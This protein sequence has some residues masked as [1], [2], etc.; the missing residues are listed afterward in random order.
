[1]FGF[2]RRLVRRCECEMLWP[3]P[4]PLPQTS[5]LAATVSSPDQLVERTLL[6]TTTLSVTCYFCAQVLDAQYRQLRN[7]TGCLAP[8]PN[9]DSLHNVSDPL[10]AFDA[11]AVLAWAR[12]ATAGLRAER[13]RI[14]ALN[15]FPVADSD[16]GTNLLLTFVD[17]AT[18]L[19]SHLEEKENSDVDAGEALVVLA[20]GALRGARGSSGTI[21]SQ[22]LFGVATELADQRVIHRQDFARALRHA[23]DSAWEAVSAPK[24]GTILSVVRAAADAATELEGAASAVVARTVAAART[25]LVETQNQLDVLRRAGVVDAGGT[26]LLVIFEALLATVAGREELPARSAVAAI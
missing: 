25:A 7:S 19:E 21:L 14:D 20:R 3:K 23:A 13:A 24:S 6:V 16:T 8:A 17:G 9:R 4:G 10:L 18:A 15:V 2:Q 22:I 1:M 12:L 26:G 5:Q 11:P